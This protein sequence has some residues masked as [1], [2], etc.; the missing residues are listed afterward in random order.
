MAEEHAAELDAARET[1]REASSGEGTTRGAATLT[2]TLTLIGRRVR[3][4]GREESL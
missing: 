2:L 1:W 3:G 4:M